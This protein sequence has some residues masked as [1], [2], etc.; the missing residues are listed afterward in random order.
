MSRRSGFGFILTGLILGLGLGFLISLVL[1]PVRYDNI[2]PSFLGEKE[3]D[4][5]RALIAAS[6]NARG[7]LGRAKARLALIEDPNP[8][9]ILAAQAQQTV[10]EGGIA[11]EARGLAYLAAAMSDI[12]IQMDTEAPEVTPTAT[13]GP[14]EF[15]TLP[16]LET[17]TVNPGTDITPTPTIADQE[18][19]FPTLESTVPV[20]DPYVLKDRKLV[21]DLEVSNLLQ[22]YVVD[23]AG[24]SVPGVEAIITWQGG[25]EDFYTGLKPQIDLG[26]ADYLM[27]PDTLYNLRLSNGSETATK[28]TPPNCKLDSGMAYKGGVKLIFGLP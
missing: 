21:C 17:E 2:A 15:P 1:S 19:Y 27:D 18:V 5:Y 8:A 26:Y 16:P 7:D 4:R 22:V 25:E 12:P 6:Y 11:Q 10:A 3:K 23:K 28:I 20:G 9:K 13:E 24:N 14:T